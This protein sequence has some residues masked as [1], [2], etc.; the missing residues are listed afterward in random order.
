MQLII[1][2][3]V[4]KLYIVARQICVILFARSERRSKKD[5]LSELQESTFR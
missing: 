5:S 4:S 2:L 1:H 3:A